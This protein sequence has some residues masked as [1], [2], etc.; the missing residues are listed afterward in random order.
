MIL[1]V[2]NIRTLV[3]ITNSTGYG[4]VVEISESRNFQ[5]WIET[6]LEM[7]RKHTKTEWSVDRIYKL[8]HSKR[9]NFIDPTTG[10]NLRLIAQSTTSPRLYDFLDKFSFGSYVNGREQKYKNLYLVY[11]GLVKNRNQ[12]FSSVRHVISHPELTNLEAREVIES[13]F[14][15]VRIDLKKKKHNLIFRGLC[16]ELQ[17]EVDKLLTEYCLRFFQNSKD[18]ILDYRL[19]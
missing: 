18:L 12:K 4:A 6:E 9:V 2:L 5:G 11:E 15:S 1:H 7:Y 19:V 8:P 17:E 13:L 10:E 3:L 16:L 14:G